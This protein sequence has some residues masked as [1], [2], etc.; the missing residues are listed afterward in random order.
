MA[1]ASAKAA[2]A[3][4]TAMP[5]TTPD[6]MPALPVLSPVPVLDSVWTVVALAPEPVPEPFFVMFDSVIVAV[7]MPPLLGPVVVGTGWLCPIPLRSSLRQ[8]TSNA[9][10]VMIVPPDSRVANR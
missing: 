6:S 2:S 9:G 5:A 1:I 4:A 10:A 3:Q 7:G 8:R